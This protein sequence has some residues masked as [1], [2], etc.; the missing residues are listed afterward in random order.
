[1]CWFLADPVLPPSSLRVSADCVR[2]RGGSLAA[3]TFDAE[4]LLA[5]HQSV[6]DVLFQRGLWLN[7]DILNNVRMHMQ[8]ALP[9]A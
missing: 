7:S 5:W 4:M 2:R 1:M 8:K 3:A 9:N 6:R